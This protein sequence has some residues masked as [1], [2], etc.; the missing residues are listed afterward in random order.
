M[1]QVG[2]EATLPG[3]TLKYAR[4]NY[5]Y[6]QFFPMSRRYTLMLNGN[7]GIASGYGGKD[8]PFW[9]NFYAGG[10]G[11]LRGFENGTL[12]PHD[13]VTGDYLGGIRRVTGTAEVLFPIPGLGVTEKAT[14]MSAFVDSGQVWGKGEKMSLSDIRFSTGLS[15]SWTSPVGPLKISVA[16][17]LRKK[18]IDKTQLFQFQLGSTF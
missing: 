9:K 10:I 5:Q 17:A 7:V 16:K 12:G 6:Q 18:E 1:Q 14:R 15:V 2:M 11:S 8:M 13:P 4:A 3:G